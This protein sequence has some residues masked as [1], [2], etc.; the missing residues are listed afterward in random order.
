M[1]SS[2]RRPAF[3]ASTRLLCVALLLFVAASVAADSVVSRREADSFARKILTIA[4]YGEAVLAGARLTPI[5]EGELNAYL[6]LDLRDQLPA[7]VVD[8]SVQ[9]L[10]NGRLVGQA[11]IDLDAVRRA[12]QS[13]GPFDPMNLLTGRLPVTA[14]GVLRTERGRARF[15]LESAAVGGIP[16]P[17][18]VLQELV[19]HYSRS[20]EWPNGIDLDASFALPARITDIH[21]DTGRAVVVQR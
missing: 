10:G 20:P 4:Q 6:R 1:I 17:K 13:G 21:V 16:V 8:P 11:T 2:G 14:A 9:A 15:E 18:S 5:T 3:A 19:T 7:G 12:R